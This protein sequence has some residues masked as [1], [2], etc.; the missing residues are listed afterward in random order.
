M[1]SLPTLKVYKARITVP[2]KPCIPMLEIKESVLLLALC[3]FYL[4]TF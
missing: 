4:V 3:I 1:L 2:A